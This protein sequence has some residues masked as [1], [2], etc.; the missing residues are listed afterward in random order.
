MNFVLL[1]N[2]LAELKEKVSRGSPQE[3]LVAMNTNTNNE[4]L[5]VPEREV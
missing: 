5:L 1:G 4:L 3:S 2:S